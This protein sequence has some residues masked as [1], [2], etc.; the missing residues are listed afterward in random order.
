LMVVR[1]VEVVRRMAFE[2]KR[3]LTGDADDVS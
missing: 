2:S 3:C 1:I